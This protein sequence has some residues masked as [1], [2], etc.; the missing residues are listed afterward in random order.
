[1]KGNPPNDTLP[2]VVVYAGLSHIT[3]SVHEIT[4]TFSAL[5]VTP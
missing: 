1:M 3:S 5:F 4:R 2:A